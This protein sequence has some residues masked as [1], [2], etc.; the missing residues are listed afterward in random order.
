VG[1]LLLLLLYVYAVLGANLFYAVAWRDGGFVG[2]DVNFRDFPSA[3]LLLFRALTGE[4]WN[5]LMHDTMVQ[6]DAR[7]LC[8]Q[9]AG[10][11]VPLHE[12]VPIIYF[13]SF[14]MLSLICLNLVI[15]VILEQQAAMSNAS[16]LTARELEHFQE[17]RARRRR[18]RAAPRRA[19]RA[20][21]PPLTRFG[22]ASARR[23]PGPRA[24]AGLVR[25]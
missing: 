18:T 7:G 22:C 23:R 6:E 16:R 11:C 21:R 2:E 4:S 13:F 24:R 1:G 5:G 12:V 3:F 20:S 14:V 15:A 17:V 25:L 8:S 10:S 9:A 19:A